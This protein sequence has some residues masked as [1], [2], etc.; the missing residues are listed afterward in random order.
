[1]IASRVAHPN[2]NRFSIR[3]ESTKHW[4][5]ECDCLA[6][7]SIRGGAGFEPGEIH[8]T[9]N[10]LNTAYRGFPPPDCCAPRFPGGFF[11]IL[12]VACFKVPVTRLP[13]GPDMFAENIFDH[14]IRTVDLDYGNLTT[15][16]PRIYFFLKV[17]GAV[18]WPFSIVIGCGL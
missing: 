2:S 9:A 16:P 7:I 5:F 8:T 18:F 12:Y 3:A 10:L 15:S 14:P 17:E 6:P 11:Q 4:G 1:M 13:P